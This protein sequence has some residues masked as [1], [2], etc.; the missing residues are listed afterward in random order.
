MSVIVDDPPSL[1][2][3]WVEW[4]VERCRRGRELTTAVNHRD[5][6]ALRL[7]RSD[8][9]SLT[10]DHPE[11]DEI[12]NLLRSGCFLA[13]SSEQPALPP[14]DLRAGMPG[15]TLFWAGADGIIRRW[16]AR[17][18]H[19]FFR[20]GVV[21]GQVALAVAGLLGL[22]AI[23][24]GGGLKLRAEV[25]HTPFIIVLGLIAVT[26]HELG[27][28]LVTIH[29]GRH[30]RS[31]GLG[32]LW[33]SPA[34]YVDSV[35]ALLLTRRQRLIQAAAG[36]WA[37]WLAT[38]LIIIVLQ[39]VPAGS[40]VEVILHRFVIVNAI[41]IITNLLPFAGLDGSLILSDLVRE[42]D[43]DERSRAALSFR[44]GQRARDGWLTT[45]AVLNALVKMALL[46]SACFFWWQLFGNL[47]STLWSS[48]PAGKTLIG[49]L[50]F[51][52]CKRVK[53]TAWKLIL[54]MGDIP[55]VLIATFRFRLE[56]RWRVD[57]ITAFRAVPAIA[58]LN[59]AALGILAGHLQ[60]LDRTPVGQETKGGLCVRMPA[61]RHRR[62]SQPQFLTSNFAAHER[63]TDM[64]NVIWLPGNWLQ[65]LASQGGA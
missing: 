9:E 30:V 45:Y 28:A 52:S 32:L 38:S 47:V 16:S 20:R 29:Y 12:G 13:S 54:N 44:R 53:V 22:L 40:V 41:G 36:P 64:E 25:R 65:L 19:H 6:L 42:P 27:H 55:S 50:A 43:L 56:R 61:R 5:G 3:P 58:N 39:V 34:F 31:V 51:L 33:G 57:A 7:S 1:F 11:D 15:P 46:V 62:S 17:F 10:T 23:I 24:D 2:A 48:G 49:A 21:A 18:L 26:V 4:R 59:E 35:D 14:A 60:R 37:E 8:L 63:W